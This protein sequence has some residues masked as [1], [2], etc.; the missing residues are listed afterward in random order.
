[1]KFSR[2][3]TYADDTNVMITS[4]DAEKLILEAQQELANLSEWIRINKPSPNP[5]KTEYMII[6]QSRKVNMLNIS[7]ALTSKDSVIKRI[8]K[9][10][11]LGGTIDENLKRDEQFNTVK[12]KICGGLASLKKLKNLIPKKAVHCL[13]CHC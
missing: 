8:I 10:K 9:M 3:S 1:M 4:D 6:G 5:T 2:A 11:S 7:N 13:L 12:G